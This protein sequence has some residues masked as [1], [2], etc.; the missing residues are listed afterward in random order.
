MSAC[1]TSSLPANSKPAQFTTTHW[2]L[3][4]AAGQNFSPSSEEAVAKL[5][6]N[7]WYPLYYYV[8]RQGH[9]PEDAEDLTQQFFARLL[10]KNYLS[11]ASRDRG[12]FRSF[13]LGSMKHFLVNEWKR[14]GRL[15]RGGGQSF[16]SF[17]F[18][19]AESR[20]TF[21]P[22][23]APEYAYEKQWA[24]ALVEQVIKGLTHEY[25]A[26]G[27]GALYAELKGFIWGEES[28]ASYAEIGCRLNMAEGAVKVSVHRLRQRFSALLRAEV[29][30][31]VSG[32]EEIDD[33][34]RHLIAVLS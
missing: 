17:D 21:E 13:L 3:V 5:C 6:E 22:V 11:K 18:F 29:A 2:S 34:L 12:K 7:Y 4:F 8:R 14:T 20:Y 23:S 26:M 31:T 28:S 19:R 30:N 25:G 9:G 32:S 15:K 1:G 33:E 16:I 24:V 27:K 10:E